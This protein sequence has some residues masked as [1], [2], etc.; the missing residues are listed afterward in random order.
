MIVVITTPQN[1]ISVKSL[2][3]GKFGFPIPRLMLEDYDSLLRK[4]RI[5]KA[6]YVFADLERLSAKELRS[7]AKFYR[8]LTKQGLRCLNNPAQ[9]MCR[10][11]LLQS[12]HAA[13]I[14]PFSVVRADELRRPA[15]YPVFLRVEDNHWKPIS[16]LL[17]DQSELE[18]RLRRLRA[19]GIPLRGL[20][21]V[22]Y[23]A[24]PYAE[25]LWAKW[26]T[27]KIG[28]R[29]SVDHI[30]VED[31]WLVKKGVWENLTDEAIADERQAVTTNR[32]AEVL[33]PAFE[34]AK[35]EWGRADHAVVAGRSVIY[36]INT[37]P[38]LGP[39][40]PD[41]NTIRRSTQVF[42]RKRIA[43]ALDA[44]DTR[45]TGTVHLPPMN[46]KQ[47]RIWAFIRIPWT[48]SGVPPSRS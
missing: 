17:N 23:C 36:E 26:G 37:A 4:R 32:F 9:A 20:L 7:A 39:Y 16:A 3:D 18:A 35:I 44:I 11:E 33:K 22:E 43:R 48:L 31:N 30:A 8:N 10:V 28:S 13:G 24:E 40:V 2:A 47:G 21:I 6:T 46:E 27:F 25:G 14:N 34:I 42:A 41:P 5:P 29:T 15:R 19:R 38:Y 45:S 1:R 12:L